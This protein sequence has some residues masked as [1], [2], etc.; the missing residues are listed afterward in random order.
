MWGQQSGPTE[1]GVDL[2]S[3]RNSESEFPGLGL[4]LLAIIPFSVQS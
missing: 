1:P 2:R 4:Q 3:D